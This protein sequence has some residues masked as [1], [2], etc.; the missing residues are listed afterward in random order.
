MN[1]IKGANESVWTI[2]ADSGSTPVPFA[3]SPAVEKHSAWSPDGKQPFFHAIASNRLVI[4][5]IRAE[6][7]VTS[8]TPVSLAIDDAIHPLTQRNYD[9]MPDGKGLLIVLPAQAEASDT[10]RRAAMQINV[11][12][13]WQEELKARV[14]MK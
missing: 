12:L 7:G 11:V 6:Q 9:V 13:D 14:P 10:K 8:G 3:D 1:V 4:V 5:D 2:R